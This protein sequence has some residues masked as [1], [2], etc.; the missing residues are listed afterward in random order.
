MRRISS[1]VI[2]CDFFQG[3]LLFVF[4]DLLFFGE[5]FQRIVAV[6][7]DIADCGAVLFEDT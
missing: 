4:A 5:L 7:A 6:A 3:A 2:F 1:S